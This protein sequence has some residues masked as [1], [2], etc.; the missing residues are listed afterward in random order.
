M[1]LLLSIVWMCMVARYE[2]WIDRLYRNIEAKTEEI[3]LERCTP[4]S[5]MQP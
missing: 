4:A 5:S 3:A 1:R 2:S